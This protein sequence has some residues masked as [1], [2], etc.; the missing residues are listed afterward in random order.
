[1]FSLS[2]RAAKAGLALAGL[3]AVAPPAL[4]QSNALSEPQKKAVEQI[5]RDY[6]LTNPEVIQEAIVEL[7]RRQQEAQ[8]TAQANALQSEKNTLLHSPRGNLVGNPSGDVT[9]VEFFDYNCAYCKRALADVRTLMKGDPKLRVVLKDFPVLG[10]ESVEAS[11][12]A[13]AVKQQISGEKLFDYHVRV[14][15]TRGR[16][17]GER[18]LQVAKDMGLDMARLQKDMDNP[19]VRAALQE[20][21]GL[22]D[23]LGLTGTPAFVIGD[24]VV[25]GAVGL[26]PLRKI[27][28][29]TRQCGKAMC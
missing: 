22:G 11:R 7:E 2:S 17:N 13:L 24:E 10:P 29:S 25:S 3:L 8:K 19:E 15:E 1:M 18:A 5:V 6:L 27:V 28:A 23:K 14:M 4:A 9:L 21:L 16:V 20:N 26:E 12:V